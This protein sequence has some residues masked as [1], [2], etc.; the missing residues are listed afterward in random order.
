MHLR[1]SDNDAARRVPTHNRC[2][3]RRAVIRGSLVPWK[4][5]TRR[6]H[7]HSGATH[8]NVYPVTAVFRGGR[9]RS[10]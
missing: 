6:S 8:R 1:A 9:R 4:R 3:C 7:I 5:N 10:L 2:R